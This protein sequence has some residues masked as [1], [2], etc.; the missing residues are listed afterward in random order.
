[1]RHTISPPSTSGSKRKAKAPKKVVDPR[2][3]P[4]PQPGPS[5]ERRGQPSPQRRGQPSPQRRG[6]PSP[7]RRAQP[8][9]QRRAQSPPRRRPSRA[10]AEHGSPRRKRRYRPGE[11]ALMEIRKFQKSTNLLIHRLPFSRSARSLQ[12][13]RGRPISDGRQQ[14][15]LHCKRPQRHSWCFCSRTPTTALSMP[16]GRRYMFKTSSWRGVYVVSM[17]CLHDP[18]P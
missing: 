13:S 9:P 1:M 14:P 10:G 12:C 17:A 18:S 2:R 3:P 8:S 11:R 15:C 6:Q 16:N 7:Q 4:S 5:T